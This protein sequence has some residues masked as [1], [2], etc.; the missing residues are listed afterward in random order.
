MDRAVVMRQQGTWTRWEQVMEHKT[1]WNDLWKLDSQS[2]KFLIMVVY[3]ILP[4]SSNLHHWGLE[5]QP[6][7]S[8][9]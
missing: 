7:C 9:C 5:E 1:T 2:I 3:D 4:S 6:I 8:L